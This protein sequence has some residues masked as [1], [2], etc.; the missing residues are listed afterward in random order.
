[1][2]VGV[3]AG[4]DLSGLE[5]SIQNAEKKLDGFVKKSEEVSKV[6]TKNF[7][8]IAKNGVGSLISAI[9]DAQKAMSKLGG[10]G[11]KNNP[12][13]SVNESVVQT[14]KH[15]TQFMDL[16][17]KINND[18]ANGRRSSAVTKLNEDIESAKKR[19][20]ELQKLLNFYTKGE[21]K[22]AVGFTDTT[23]IQQ[24]AKSLMFRLDALEREK[25]SLQANERLRLAIAQRQEERD[26]RWIKMSEERVKRIKRE[27]KESSDAAKIN[28][29]SIAQ[30]RES[31]Q[32]M[33]EK[34]FEKAIGREYEKIWGSAEEMLKKQ[35]QA[36]KNRYEMWL[37]Q[38]HKE[39]KE[40][41]RIEEEKIKAT[42]NAIAKQNAEY[43]KSE[44]L[45]NAQAKTNQQTKDNSARIKS[46]R[47]AMYK[48]YEQMF[49]NIAKKNGQTA[50]QII[51]KNQEELRQRR[52]YVNEMTAMYERMFDEIA[53]RESQNRASKYGRIQSIGD[54]T[55]QALAAYN[56]LYSDKGVK[57]I[58]N[59]NNALQRLR[60]AQS[61]LNINTEEGRKKY[62]QLGD[63]I[64]RVEK[65]MAKLS[66]QSENVNKKQSQL[67]DIG[68][69]L[70]RR[71]A[72]VFSVSQ[73]TGYINKII[74]VRGEFELQQ[75][76]LQVLIGDLDKAN[77]IWNK[78]VALAVKSPFTVKNL[79]TYTKQLA[80]YRV[81]SEKLYDTT[82]MLADV[83]AGLGV[84]M[85]RL[86]LAYGQVKAANF[87]RGTELRQFTEAGVNMLGELSA[88]F[89]EIE[90]KAVSVGDVF[91]RISKRRVS[92]EAVD[93]VFK[94]ITGEG[95]VFYQMQ[96]K[97]SQTL[98][99]MMMNLRDSIDLMMNDIGKSND[100]V[101]KDTVGLIR[102]IIN[103]WRSLEPILKT[104]GVTFL[105]YFS[106]S[107]LAKIGKAA[108]AIMS[109]FSANP[110][111]LSITAIA[112]LAAG[113]YYAKNATD[114]FNASLLEVEKNVTQSLEESIGLYK[115]LVD[116]INDATKTQVER[117][118]AYDQL[119][120]K[121]TEILPDQ[122]LEIEYVKSLS[123]NYKEA[124][125]AMF[126]Y[127]NAK[128]KAQKKDR[129]EQLYTSEL[130]DTDI[131]ELQ[132]SIRDFIEGDERIGERAKIKLKSGIVGVVN[133]LVDDVKSGKINAT[134]EEFNK[135]IVERL[136]AYAGFNEQQK[137]AFGVLF[138]SENSIWTKRRHNIEDIIETLQRYKQS[139][140]SIS[141]L[142]YGTYEEE[143]AG[144]IVNK[145]L[146]NVNKSTELFKQVAGLYENYTQIVEKSGTTIEEQQKAITDSV[147]QMLEKLKKDAPAYGNYMEGVFK[148]LEE[149]AKKGKFAYSEALQSIES[150]MYAKRGE[151]GFE[152]GLGQLAF[153][154]AKKKANEEKLAVSLVDNVQ[155]NLN[156]KAEELEFTAFQKAVT[157]GA[158]NIAS[159]FKIDEDLFAQFIPKQGQ[160]LSNLQEGLKGFIEQ[161]EKEIE[162]L[163]TSLKVGME[164][165]SYDV[166]D[167]TKKKLDELKNSLPALKEFGK[168][169][170]IDEKDKGSGG[171]S[172][173]L[174]D[175][176]IKV[177]D[178]LNKKY[179]ELI[180]TVGHSTAVEEAFASYKDAFA[181][182]YKGISWIPS[183]VR[184]MS[185]AEF[186]EK[187][188]NFPSEAALVEFL[189]ELAKEPMKVFEK[190]KVE[191]AKGK[192][193]FDAEVRDIKKKDKEILDAIDDMFSGYEI[194]LE[195]EKLNIPRDLAQRLFPE[196]S[197]ATD[198]SVIRKKIE[199]D[200]ETAKKS[201][202]K[203]DQVR[204]LEERLK[205]VKDLED[206]ELKERLKK[207]SKYLTTAMGERVKIK[208]EELR[209]IEEIESMSQLSSDQKELAK[210]GVKKESQAKMD[211][212]S[213][214]EFKDSGMYVQLF[215]DLEYASTRSLTV[216]REKL[217]QLKGSLKDL[218]ADDLRNLY[219]QI[220]KI[221]EQLAKRNP[222]KTFA[223]S[224]GD[225]INA[226]KNTKNLEKDL[227]TKQTAYDVT[228]EQEG[229]VSLD[230]AKLRAEYE[231]KAKS[232]KLTDEESE[233]Y[234]KNIEELETQLRIL[235]KILGIRE[236]DVKKAQEN[237]DT[238]AKTKKS[239]KE[240]AKEVGSDISQV[241]SA[242]P[243]LASDMENIFGAMDA[244]TRDTIESIAEIG[245]GIGQA[246][247]G[248]ASGDYISGIMGVSQAISGIFKVG[249]KK[250][251]REIQRQIERVERLGK[252]YETLEKQIEKAYAIDTLKASYDQAQNTL[253]AQVAAYDK[254]IAQEE[255]KKKSDKKRIDEWKEAKEELTEQ[256]KE[257]QKEQIESM[258]GTYDYKDAT[259]E[260]VDAWVE[261]FNET[262]NGL[263][264]LEDHFDDFWKNI[265][266]NQ[267]VMGG[268][269]KIMQPLIDKINKSLEDD[270]KI[271]SGEDKAIDAAADMAMKR[272]D[273]FMKLS[274]DKWG[275]ALTGSEAGELTGL[276]RGIQ[277]IS[278]S[279]ADILAAYLNSIRMYVSQNTEH[280]LKISTNFDSIVENPI[281]P[282]LKIIAAQ[283]EKISTLLENV[284]SN[285]E[286]TAFKVR[287]LEE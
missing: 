209:Q 152:G 189:D 101:L 40:H 103:E 190:I 18:G 154:Q 1:M 228:K 192:Y 109:A 191:L 238:N 183:N 221:D 91:D 105:A 279:Q 151:K 44:A 128:A 23:A 114:K 33:Y 39:A 126:N 24:E 244:G 147:S 119:K 22:K 203:E 165:L 197:V 195:L 199:N 132:K 240:A 54:T 223:T 130:E 241:S 136:S 278:E 47:D 56:R 38:K 51:K 7:Q 95:G 258:G 163:E 275:D 59:M 284:S 11:S 245:G 229:I 58:N 271:D 102:S 201:G 107:K 63:A 111:T 79:V 62:S 164:T 43:A 49:D 29:Q 28:S 123:G 174:Y 9:S 166:F 181:E 176:R 218:D 160:A 273:E 139:M 266:L 97:Q 239:F 35:Q 287:L 227:Q 268:A 194:S 137:E 50:E 12:M 172:N 135:E 179:R 84:D 177:I 78:T 169:L 175:E 216:M 168:F 215:E 180:A 116:I 274:Y 122:L 138:E 98:R 187:V 144:E 112:A 205:K 208:M 184:Q 75:K 158:K 260:F 269:S 82:K 14:I 242:L 129:I 283:T 148:R 71:L 150:E 57:S 157:E 100:G 86:I 83:S 257:L 73:I 262:G 193:V 235:R 173:S 277:G 133:S 161:R 88:Y 204:E 41:T 270:F 2:A 72:L 140:Q 120:Q 26:N 200:L 42:Q 250:K 118:K 246:V 264:G 69:Q 17:A 113:I 143:K 81:E 214:E 232:K 185:A 4:F 263:K 13:K 256:Y 225:Y 220:E 16:M 255:D 15:T 254:M 32:R 247:Q 285:N 108:T 21:G 36:E 68:G 52:K 202:G 259:R 249:D 27:S 93:A 6:V 167:Q 76:S 77:E 226:V 233:A 25:A 198:L 153:D 46:E 92:F 55:S 280:L 45:R 90:G 87:L 61:K 131:P 65:D 19:L 80:A 236:K 252:Q 170:G 70:Q 261:A 171:R 145:E 121:F 3:G 134:L 230:L 224:I 30:N 237:L 265:V 115:K 188:L 286:R 248:F 141:G 64:K 142:S 159:K 251:E 186:V 60:D 124:E 281:L 234:L 34:L 231:A 89:S 117:N 106:V 110:I 94:R 149:A 219:N 243:Q 48:M 162:E 213:W 211:K 156:R 85:Q 146:E 182:A 282:Q 37:A 127:Y 212:L 196:T 96:E 207:Y 53:R 31:Q 74:Q 66:Q 8:D 222:F 5:K 267:V 99:G 210:Q 217:E 10:S 206:K 155:E 276:Q 20:E 67:L 253:R 104:A 125:T 178:D 272:L